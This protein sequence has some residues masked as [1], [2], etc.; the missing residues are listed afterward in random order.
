MTKIQESDYKENKMK[1]VAKTTKNPKAFT[2]VELLTVMSI[3]VV[4]I[5]LLVPALNKVRQF[6][7]TVKQKA[8]FHSMETAIEMFNNEFEGYPPSSMEDETGASYC[9]AMKLCEAM[10]GRDL[11]GFHPNS[12]FRQDGMDRAG[13]AV[14]LP[15]PDNLKA[16][17]GPYLPLESA[18]AIQLGDIYGAGNT[19]TF[20]EEIYVLCDVFKKTRDTGE[21]VGMPVLYYKADTTGTLHDPNVAQ[22]MPMDNRG[23]IYNYYDNTQL[24]GLGKP[25]ATGAQSTHKLADMN[26]FYKCT[27]SDKIK[28]PPR[29]YKASSY[30]L[31]SAGFDGEYGTADDVYNFDWKSV[32]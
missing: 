5:G 2:I 1:P 27:K 20:L 28:D 4:L 8:Q 23:F 24:V 26:W 32:N 30:I 6:S 16:R 7:M 11:L 21:K 14:Y 22:P 3:I 13:R 31:I 18:N 10:M 29:P 12:V 19:D 25:G 17:S 9:G 15:D